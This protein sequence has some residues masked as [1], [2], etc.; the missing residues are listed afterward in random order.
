MVQKSFKNK[1]YDLKNF[2][3]GPNGKEIVN[4][5]KIKAMAHFK[6]KAWETYFFPLF[7]NDP[8]IFQNWH[9]S[10][11]NGPQTENIAK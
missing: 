7:F 9:S 6:I 2:Q 3:N 8:E 5:A 11:F 1:C 4:R 10:S